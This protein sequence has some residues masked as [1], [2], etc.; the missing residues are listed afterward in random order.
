M[1]KCSFCGT[2][3]KEIQQTGFVGCAH[4][5]SEITQLQ[6]VVLSLYNGKKYK[7]KT[8]KGV[9]KNGSI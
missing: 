4:C 1:E 7:G 3:Y 5:Y 9:R 8:P 6:D 2:S